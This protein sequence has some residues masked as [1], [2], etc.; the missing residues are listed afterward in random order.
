MKGTRIIRTLG[1]TTVILSLLLGVQATWAGGLRDGSLYGDFMWVGFADD[2]EEL[3]KPAAGW[4]L[5]YIQPV[6]PNWA[7]GVEMGMR[8]HSDRA[9]HG[10]EPW[11]DP[12]VRNEELCCLG[13]ATDFT[14]VPW[15]GQVFMKAPW[16]QK[17]H[18][19]T[20]MWFSFGIGAYALNWEWSDLGLE[21]SDTVLGLNSGA[22]LVWKKSDK[23]A[24]TTAV[25]YH[26]VTTDDLFH[27]IDPYHMF[28]VRLGVVFRISGASQ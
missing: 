15:I 23:V 7:I 8:K 3:Y 27:G 1:L 18:R 20:S 25:V 12:G 24:L 10:D 5:G 2:L 16:C 14:V 26:H 19:N 28:D 21:K 11:H 13:P 9:R 4:A 17:K 22:H 6:S